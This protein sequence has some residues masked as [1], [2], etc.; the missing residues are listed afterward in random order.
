MKHERRAAAIVGTEVAEHEH[1]GFIARVLRY[2][3]PA[4]DF[5]T[6]W[7]K[8]VA[9]AGLEKRSPV[10][11]FGHSWTDPIG[12]T[13]RWW[14]EDDGLFMEFA[15]DDPADV[16]RARQARAQVRSGTLRDVSIGFVREASE[17]N[18]DGTVNITKATID[19]VSIVLRG[20][21]SGAQVLAVRSGAVVP[22]AAVAQLAARLVTGDIDIADFLNEVK[23]ASFVPPA[24]GDPEEGDGEDPPVVPPVESEPP[25]EFDAELDAQLDAAL[26][27]ALGRSAR[28]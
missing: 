6:T 4:D 8:G 18:D 24:S 20:A 23:T 3:A 17:P 9:N 26:G 11:A 13:T 27:V 2:G 14:E 25:D 10:L 5:G 1:G 28:R 19:E 22:A 12:R 15:F 7:A 21:V 16:P